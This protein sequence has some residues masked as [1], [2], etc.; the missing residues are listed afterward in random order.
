MVDSDKG[1]D[2]ATQIGNSIWVA[3][4]VRCQCMACLSQ[5]KVL[6]WQWFHGG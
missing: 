4:P 1:C 2:G 6:M 3:V 5:L